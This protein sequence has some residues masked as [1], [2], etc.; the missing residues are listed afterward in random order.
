MTVTQLRALAKELGI[1][2]ASILEE[3]D[4][5]VRKLVD[6]GVSVPDQKKE[7]NAAAVLVGL[8]ILLALFSK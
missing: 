5:M 8:G 2:P 7:D 1:T 3:S 6:A 4:G